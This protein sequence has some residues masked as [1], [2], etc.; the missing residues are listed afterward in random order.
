MHADAQEYR[1]YGTPTCKKENLG[2]TLKMN[3]TALLTSVGVLFNFVIVTLNF[4]F[5]SFRQ[6][7]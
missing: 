7:N 1:E 2:R 3:A 5:V 4:S 6:H